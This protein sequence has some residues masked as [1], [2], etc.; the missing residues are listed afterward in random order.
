MKVPVK[1]RDLIM[2]SQN[3]PRVTSGKQG[4]CLLV[5]LVSKRKPVELEI[6]S[7]SKE[8]KTLQSQITLASYKRSSNKG[9]I[10]LKNNPWMKEQ[11]REPLRL[12]MALL[13]H[14]TGLKHIFRARIRWR[15][16][17]HLFL[18]PLW[19]NF[20]RILSAGGHSHLTGQN[21]VT[22]FY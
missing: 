11:R 3:I 15:R 9:T 10:F 20:L 14:Y 12:K 1:P 8:V 17:E 6:S 18:C 21:W 2:W 13:H 7:T 16:R 4:L 19:E 22:C 5:T